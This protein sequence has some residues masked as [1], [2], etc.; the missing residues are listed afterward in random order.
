MARFDV[1]GVGN[2]LVDIQVQVD[3]E[4]LAAHGL[5]KGVMTLVTA[6]KQ[7]EL[8]DLVGHLPTKTSPGGSACNTV[9][10]LANFGGQAYYAGKVGD[11]E[12]G[13]YFQTALTEVGIH[14]TVPR[15]HGATGTCLVMITPDADRTMQT[16]LAASI[17]LDEDDIQVGTLRDSRYVYI[18]GYLWDSPGPQ[19][20][21]QRAMEVARAQGVPVAFT[22][23]DPFCVQ[24]A[25]EDFRN[26]TRF[27]VDLVFCNEEEARMITATPDRAQ[28]C[29]EIASWGP[30]VFMTA[31][32]DGAYCARGRELIHIPAFQVTALDT[33]GA[34]DLFAGGVLYGL[35]HGLTPT[36]A[37]KLGAYAAARVVSVIGPRLDVRLAD[38]IEHILA[39]DPTRRQRRNVDFSPIVQVEEARKRGWVSRSHFR[40]G[41][42]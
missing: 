15:G 40:F 3:A 39:L 9:V 12:H 8:L 22:Y 10:G 2:A 6:R 13:A 30:T 35:T 23:S 4:F 29:A 31:G 28:A 11:D 14:S 1:Y 5:E 20:A 38:D 36:E 41:P 27:A 24:R 26:L 25:A 16:C 32:A 34:G 7:R 33:N 17:E 21:S 19:R 42:T 37:G 18:E